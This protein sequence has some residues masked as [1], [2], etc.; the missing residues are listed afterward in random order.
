[1]A[2]P[3]LAQGEFIKLCMAPRAKLFKL[4]HGRDWN[5][6]KDLFVSIKWALVEYSRNNKFD[7]VQMGAIGHLAALDRWL[8]RAYCSH[9]MPRVIRDR[10]ELATKPKHHAQ[11][12]LHKEYKQYIDKELR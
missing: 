7:D 8:W 10:P 12:I 11:E 3:Q 1:M 4:V 6:I 9:E 5:K 2:R